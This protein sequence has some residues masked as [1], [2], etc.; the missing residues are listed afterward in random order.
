MTRRWLCN[1]SVILVG[2]EATKK[3][4][5]ASQIHRHVQ[6]LGIKHVGE[7]VRLERERG[8]VGVCILKELLHRNGLWLGILGL[9]PL[10]LLFDSSCTGALV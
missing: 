5:G 2:C 3:L 6:I 4:A 7:L 8:W 1:N 10:S 9:S